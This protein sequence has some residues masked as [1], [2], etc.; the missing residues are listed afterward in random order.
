MP[1]K[2]IDI[3]SARRSAEWVRDYVER[4]YLTFKASNDELMR[5]AAYNKPGEVPYPAEFVRIGIGIPYSG[6]MRCGHDPHI[7]ARLVAD[8]RTDE[9]GKLI[10]T[11]VPPPDLP[12]EFQ[13]N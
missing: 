6:Q 7:Y 1:K 5:Y 11:D 9:T 8:L 2:V 4:L 13:R 10:W 3:V 12:E